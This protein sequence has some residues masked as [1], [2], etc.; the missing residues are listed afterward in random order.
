MSAQPEPAIRSYF[1]G[2]AYTDL[3]DTIVES[4]RRN[5]DSAREYWGEAE[6]GFSGELAD[7]GK[8]TLWA[9]AAVAVVLFGTLLFATLSLLH[10]VLLAVVFLLVYTGFTVVYL[11]ERSYMLI[12]RFAAVC[13]ACHHNLPLPEYLC[14]GCG[15]VHRRLVPSSYG[16]LRRTCNCGE[17]LPATFFLSRGELPS[18]CPECEQPLERGN[19]ESRKLFVP[20]VGGPAVG[21]TAFLY[22][23]VGSL[24]DGDGRTG[25]VTEFFSS[26]DESAYARTRTAMQGGATPSKTTQTLPYAFTLRVTK[27]RGERVLYLYDPA[28]EAYATTEGQVLHRYHGYLSGL[29]LLVDPFSIP[30]LRLDYADRIAGVEGELKPSELP[31]EDAL[32]RVFIALEENHGMKPSERLRVPVAVVVNKVDAFDLEQDLTA[33]GEASVRRWLVLHGLGDVV[34]LL[35]ERCQTVRY[36]AC[37][38]LGRMPDVTG[39]PFQPR[40]VLEPLIWL[41]GEAD[42]FFSRSKGYAAS[43]LP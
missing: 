30:S 27:G 6:P 1:F 42:P 10:V 21:K 29:V 23:A 28:G 41:L 34:Q 2:K 9:A 18:R 37:S 3:R 26:R 17:V 33:G 32:S 25:L 4:W 12:R 31:T 19:V 22:A 24:V 13:P 8:A 38:A 5:L 7:K 40:G 36:F 11:M 35:E 14:P 43:L 16:I 39:E 20:L 15:A